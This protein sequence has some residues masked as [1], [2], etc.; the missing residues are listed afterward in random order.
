MCDLGGKSRCLR[1]SES[2]QCSLTHRA[3]EQG[4]GL[5]FASWPLLPWDLGEVMFISAS[6]LQ[7][8]WKCRKRS[9]CQM[10]TWGA[11]KS[12]A[13]TQE[14][15]QWRSAGSE[16]FLEEVWW[17]WHLL[18]MLKLAVKQVE[19]RAFWRGNSLFKA[20]RG[21]EKAWCIG[22]KSSK[23]G[24]S[25]NDS[26]GM[27]RPGHEET[28]VP[29]EDC[30]SV[31]TAMRT[32]QRTLIHQRVKGSYTKKATGVAAWRAMGRDSRG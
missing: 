31:L 12:R 16:G 19:K 9:V 14:L 27:E 26:Q 23:Y 1:V 24:W 21:S 3:L 2:L 8:S 20:Q 32:H 5:A 18:G 4:E 7:R 29:R 15:L 10:E 30:A 17:N 13:D 28:C 11:E 25:I 6:C 22:Q